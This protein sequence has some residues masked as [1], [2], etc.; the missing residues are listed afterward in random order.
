MDKHVY[1]HAS[2]SG[3]VDVKKEKEDNESNHVTSD[4]QHHNDI[5]I[6]KHYARVSFIIPD[7]INNNVSSNA[8]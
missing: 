2:Y 7:C 5:Y 6:G 8:N 3:M 4:N 1:H